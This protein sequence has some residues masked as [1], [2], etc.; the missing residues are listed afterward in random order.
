MTRVL[1][2]GS[3]PAAAAVALALAERSD[4]EITV[5]DIGVRLDLE[6]QRVVAQLGASAPNAWSADDVAAITAQPVAV[7]ERGLPEKRT[8]GSD[9]PFRDIGQLDGVAADRHVQRTLISAAYGGFSNTWGAQITPFPA[10][11]LERW[12]AASRPRASDYEAVLG[13]I[14]YAGEHDDL[15]AYLPLLGRPATLPPPSSRTALVLSAYARH[16]R[17]VNRLGVS[18]GKARLAFDSAA[19]VR[20]GLCMT[21]CPYSLIYSSSS[22][23]DLLRATG[24]VRYHDGLMAVRAGEDHGTPFV[25]A[26]ELRSGRIQRFETDRVFLACGAI[27]TARLVMQSLEVFDQ[28]VAIEEPAQ[29]II[30]FFSVRPTPD[31]VAEPQFTLNQFN[32]LVALDDAGLALSQ[33]HFY[34][35]NPA[36]V[37]ALP[38]VLRTRRA[39][40]I[41]AQ[42]IRRLCVT[43]G[44]LPS[45][46]SPRMYVTARRR[47]GTVQDGIVP[48]TL[49]R[50]RPL[51]HKNTMLR[52]VVWRVTRA[53]RHL[54]L[55][56]LLPAMTLAD[57]G[58]S[59]HWGGAFPH[60]AH[61]ATML[62]SDV[63]GRIGPWRRIHVVDASVF[64]NVAATTYMLTIMAN[65]HRIATGAFDRAR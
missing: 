44:Y 5:I 17:A 24:R 34:T 40:P 28:P 62:E 11:A 45:W 47:P 43:I 32:M 26:K 53:A 30:P 12:P 31:P 57:G 52:T 49:T 46:E 55:W 19:C 8:Y 14:P 16:R 64:P 15:E 35:Y 2:V 6:Q 59:Y 65:A 9:F 41:V 61:P 3:G 27:G 4:V 1:I 50:D 63:L 25:L 51:W 36:F 58:K 29:F 54:D 7:D 22:T 39:A 13:K 23:F 42:L 37:D 60:R 21:G 48:M 10:A 20:C 38:A 33:L 56:P 18:V